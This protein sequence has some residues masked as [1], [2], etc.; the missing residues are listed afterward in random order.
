MGVTYTFSS[1]TKAKSSEVNTNFADVENDIASGDESLQLLGEV[2]MFALSMTGALTKANLQAK[3]WAI[4]DGTTPAS[5]GISSPTITTTPNLENKFLRGSDDETS[6]TTGGADTHK[7]TQGL[8]RRGLGSNGSLYA[9][10]SI[11]GVD[12][13]DGDANWDTQ[14]VS[15]VPAYYEVAFFIKVKVVV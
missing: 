8:T 5:Q 10:R 9:V 14:T 1:G 15:N 7:H 12:A 11:N 6:G 2:R 13:D 3:G 4:C